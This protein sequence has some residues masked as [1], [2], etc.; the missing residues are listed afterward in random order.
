VKLNDADHLVSE[1]ASLTL[2]WPRTLRADDI[3]DPVLT[4]P[5]PLSAGWQVHLTPMA[6]RSADGYAGGGQLPPAL[7]PRAPGL[8]RRRRRVPLLLL[9]LAHISG[10]AVWG[11]VVGRLVP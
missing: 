11:F 4:M 2:A 8:A 9:A 5:D 6:R 7:P 3:P 1:Y 10:W